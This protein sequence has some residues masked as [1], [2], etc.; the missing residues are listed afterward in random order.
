MA[1]SY[2]ISA[3]FRTYKMQFSELIS[4]FK[5]QGKIIYDGS[6]NTVKEIDIAGNQLNVK[7]FKVPHLINQLAYRWVRKSK[8]QR[9]FEHAEELL[10]REIGTPK[11]VAYVQNL[12]GLFL[13]DSYYFSEQLMY[14]LSY[15]NLIHE[16]NYPDRERILREFTRFTFKMHEKEVL[17]KDHSPGNTLIVKTGRT[18]AFFLVD[19]NRMEFRKLSFEERMKNFDR[20]TPKKE[21]VEIMS[22]EY[23][24]LSGNTYETVFDKM[25]QYTSE[26]REKYERKKA[27]KKKYLGK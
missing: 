2:F 1:Y 19:L 11:P 16:P 4:D 14:D 21:M 9:S 27:L 12:E 18:Y 5:N 22:D 13:K 17:F 3:P 26:F 23:A 24:R 10:A 15:R 6:R 7:A 8:A 20:L 25:W